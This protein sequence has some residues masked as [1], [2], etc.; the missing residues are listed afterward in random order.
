M[1]ATQPTCYTTGVATQDHSIAAAFAPS[2]I[3]FSHVSCTSCHLVLV[4][5]R[6]SPSHWT[7]FS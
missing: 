7:V 4:H 1:T 6:F 2:L 5:T 3:S